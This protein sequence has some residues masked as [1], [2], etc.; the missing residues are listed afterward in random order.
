MYKLS[1]KD[2]VKDTEQPETRVERDQRKELQKK[3]EHYSQEMKDLVMEFFNEKIIPSDIP[4]SLVEEYMMNYFRASLAIYKSK[5]EQFKK[6]MEARDALDL[7][8]IKD[9]TI[10]NEQN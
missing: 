2:F 6:Y 9:L 4:I 8:P 5:T 1:K 7:T 3:A 10:K